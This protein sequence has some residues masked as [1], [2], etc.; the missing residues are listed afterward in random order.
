MGAPHRHRLTTHSSARVGFRPLLNDWAVITLKDWAEI[1]RLH[2]ADEIPI[3]AIARRLGI[4]RN[5]IKSALTSVGPPKYGRAAKGSAVD[6]FE[7][8]SHAPLAAFPG[9]PATVLAERVGCT[10]SITVFRE[11][12]TQLRPLSAPADPPSRST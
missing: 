7:P 6:E 9:M 12:V 4:M 11:R 2:R 5:T 10:R 1:R 3:K 8:R